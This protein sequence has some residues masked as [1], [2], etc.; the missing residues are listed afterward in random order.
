[1]ETSTNLKNLVLMTAI[2]SAIIPLSYESYNKL[3][4]TIEHIFSYVPENSWSYNSISNEDSNANVLENEK[5]QI[6]MN[7]SQKLLSNSTELDMEFV[8]IVDDNFWDLL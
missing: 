3:A 8:E 5:L 1:M 6:V 7:F 4:P 2:S